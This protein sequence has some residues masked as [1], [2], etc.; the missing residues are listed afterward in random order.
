MTDKIA[1]AVPRVQQTL[2]LPVAM[3]ASLQEWAVDGSGLTAAARVRDSDGRIALIKN[4]WTDGWFVP[5]GAVE[6]NE[7]PVETAR[8]EV[9][10]ET[11]LNATVDAPLVVLD[12]SYISEDDEEE[13]FSA[14]FVVYAA[15]ADGEIPDASQLGV[16]ED[17]IVAARWFEALPENLHDE[18]VLRQYL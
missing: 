12:Q 17:E 14:L 8:R 15:S 4:S 1:S 16:T 18:D 5:G 7:T 11:G 3:L 10:E 2:R 6:H 9:R 13:W